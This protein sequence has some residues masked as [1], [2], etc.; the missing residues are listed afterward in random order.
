MQGTFEFT[1]NAQIWPRSLNSDIGGDNKTTYLIIADSGSPSGNGFDFV[2]G[3]TVKSL[4]CC[5]VLTIILF[6][7]LTDPVNV[8][9]P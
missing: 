6:V 4:P 3:F 1:A 9:T 7:F 5:V 2:F 8:T